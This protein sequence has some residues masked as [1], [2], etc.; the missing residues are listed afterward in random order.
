MS[1]VTKAIE[2]LEYFYKALEEKEAKPSEF[3]YNL[4]AFLSRGR[5]ITWI[6]KKQYSKFPNFSSWYSQKEKEMRADKLMKFFVDARNISVKEHSINPHFNLTI[7]HVTLTRETGEKG[8]KG[9]GIPMEGVPFWIEKNEKGE[10]I[11]TPTHEFDDRVH[12]QYYFKE[13]KPP[14]A[15][16]NLQAINLCK[17]YLDNLKEIAEQAIAL[18]E[19]QQ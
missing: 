14:K 10:E 8:E 16:R 6:I 3:T 7:R 11:R 13:P 19:K 1:A 12:R 17:I 5:S 18:F 2:E 9:L 4:N 15:F